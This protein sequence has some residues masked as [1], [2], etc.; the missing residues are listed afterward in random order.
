MRL[1]LSSGWEAGRRCLQSEDLTISAG[2]FLHLSLSLFATC[3][4]LAFAIGTILR[5]LR[6]DLSG[7][8]VDL[9]IDRRELRVVTDKNA[10]QFLRFGIGC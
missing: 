8:V 4:F 6:Y 2:A 10:R 9:V 5:V 1:W 3:L 7:R